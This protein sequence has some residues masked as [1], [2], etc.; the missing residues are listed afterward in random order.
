MIRRID[1]CD[2]DELIK[3]EN[4]TIGTTLGKEMFDLA[5]RSEIAYYYVYV[6]NNKILG[7]ISTSFDGIS[8]EVLNFC[9]YKEY[10]GKGIGTKLLCHVLDELYSKG[11][12]NSILEV[13][14]SNNRAIG[15]YSKVGYKKIH[16]RKNYYSDMEDAIVMQKLFCDYNDLYQSYMERVSKIDRNDYYISYRNDNYRIKYDYNKYEIIKYDNLDKVLKKIRKDNDRTFLEIETSKRCNDYFIDM[17]E[18]YSISMHSNINNIKLN[19]NIGKVVEYSSINKEDYL[20]FNYEEDLRYDEAYAKENGVFKVNNIEKFNNKY[21][22]YLIYD[23]DKLVGI[24]D[25]YIFLDGVFIENFVIL[26]EYRN[27]GYGSS[28]FMGMVN[29]LKRIGVFDLFLDA[30]GFDTVKDMYKKWGFSVI[31][32]YYTYHKDL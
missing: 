20:K 25:C 23:N 32:E 12:N 13:R 31:G 22:S 19:N 24:V 7:Y 30:D 26:K 29:G 11:A 1:Y 16:I 21:K 10:Q 14:E 5:V 6:E 4:E 18:A 15:L 17:I 28:L 9:V 8:I 2:I 3:L 27:K